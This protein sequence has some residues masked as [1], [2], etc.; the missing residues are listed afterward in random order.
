MRG[1]R[2]EEGATR[3][4]ANGYHYTKTEEGW[5]LTHRLVVEREVLGRSLKDDER[6]RFE[7]GDR[8]NL[9]PKNLAVYRV[10]QGSKERRRAQLL[11]RRQEIDAELEELDSP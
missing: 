9:D 8:N 2:S 6:V 10:R 7:D 4:S 3:W 1:E 5:K 11:A